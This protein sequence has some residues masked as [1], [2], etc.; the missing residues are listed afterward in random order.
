MCLNWADE[1]DIYIAEVISEDIYQK[2]KYLQD[3][4]HSWESD[5]YFGTNEGFEDFEYLGFTFEEISKDELEIL[6]KYNLP[7]GYSFMDVLFMRL[8]DAIAD[9]CSEE[10]TSDLD[11]TSCSFDAF[12]YYINKLAE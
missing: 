7:G 8:E 12:R 11:L 6:H 1:C 3:T 10:D 9:N 2:Y 4:L 5:Y